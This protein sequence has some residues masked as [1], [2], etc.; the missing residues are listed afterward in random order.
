MTVTIT[1]RTPDG[2][3]AT[4]GDDSSKFARLERSLYRDR[5]GVVFVPAA[6]FGDEREMFRAADRDGGSLMVH[7]GHVYIRLDW[8]R[9]EYRDHPYL[10]IYRR[11]IRILAAHAKASARKE[12]RS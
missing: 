4:F 10:G 8:A 3:W 9:F 2:Y 12:A 5:K 7:E 1:K 6:G 11:W